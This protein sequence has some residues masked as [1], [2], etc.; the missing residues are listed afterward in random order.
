[1]ATKI[2][3]K[4]NTSKPPS[5]T[6]EIVAIVLLGAA[7]LT[8]LSIVSFT[9]ADLPPN[10]TTLGNKHNW[11]GFVGDGDFRMGA[12]FFADWFVFFLRCHRRKVLELLL[13]F[14]T[15]PGCGSRRSGCGHFHAARKFPRRLCD[16]NFFAREPVFFH[17]RSHFFR[18]CGGGIGLG[19]L[20]RCAGVAGVQCY[21][22]RTRLLAVR[23]ATFVDRLAPCGGAPCGTGQYQRQ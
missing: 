21:G 18:S 4:Q 23:G 3:V 6:N 15:G 8:F 2:E 19:L 10:S 14:R 1:M 11:I 7:L 17:L 5:W 13:L 16:L 12:G 9:P 20:G 22:A